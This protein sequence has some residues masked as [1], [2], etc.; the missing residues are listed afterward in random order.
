M[1]ACGGDSSDSYVPN[2]PLPSAESPPSNDGQ[3]A[4]GTSAAPAPR[5]PIETIPAVA[6]GE[7]LAPLPDPPLTPPPG[8]DSE[9]SPAD[10][11]IT[12]IRDFPVVQD[13]ARMLD[14]PE[15]EISEAEF[16]EGPLPAVTTTPPSVDPTL[17]AAPFFVDLDDQTIDAGAELDLL[18]QPID[19]DGG[20]PGMFPNALPPGARYVDNLDGTRSLI[21]RP[22]Q[23][24]VGI[25]EFTITAIDPL[26]PDYRVER[27]IRIKV[28][29][30]ADTSTIEN[31]PPVVN[32]VRP[33]TVRVNDP[34]VID[35]KGSD[36]N[37]TT[38]V[39]NIE[40]P[41]PDATLTPHFFDD[42]VRV[43]G[44]VPTEVGTITLSVTATD[45]EDATL[46]GERDIT[47]EVLPAADFTRPGERLR[48]LAAARNLMIGYASLQGFY[49]RPDGAIY[50]H[51]AG[52]EFDLVTTENDLKWSLVNPL[53]G[54]Y[55]WA[56]ADNLVAFAEAKNMVV[57]GHTLVWH[58]QLPS[59]IKRSLPA[60]REGH[61][62]EYI[63][64]VMRRY[65]GDIRLWDVVNE[66]LEDDGSFR[67]SVWFEAMGEDYIDIAFRQARESAPQALLLYN[68]YDI[69]DGGPKFEAMLALV[70]DLK[71]RGTPIDGVGLQMHV[72]SDFG[73][74]AGT[75]DILQAFADLDLDIYITEL[76]VSVAEGDT[77]ADQAVVYASITE[78]CLAQPRCRALQTWGFT[79]M[80]SWRDE[81]TPLLLDERYQV[82]PAYLAM[83][84]AL[85]GD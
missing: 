51:I 61:M 53:P 5:P 8:D 9:P 42:A 11:A 68:D 37:G 66:S 35:I 64:R 63:D 36:P 18:L 73:G 69:I 15:D 19:P 65:E 40:N 84:R 71:A 16:L 17:N 55:R 74:L 12:T 80:Y 20:I 33:H 10:I 24:D 78:T 67:D 41:P 58:R 57:H 44:F 22:L 75:A 21:W 26:E 83:Q 6:T 2:G 59:W 3:P 72:F 82:K 32:L 38:P 50:A 81:Y 77:F 14:D 43:L 85:A 4:P 76:D 28:E 56:S 47:I 7:S 30:P 45:A 25:R 29:L 31:L 23:P 79:D 46:V 13:P 39:L 54:K 1:T 34:V 49:H 27:T 60:E 48:E 62:R 52:E 70:E